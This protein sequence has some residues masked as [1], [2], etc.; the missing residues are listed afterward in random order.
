MCY[1]LSCRGARVHKTNLR[2]QEMNNRMGEQKSSFLT[3][4]T[5]TLELKQL[6]NKLIG[7][8]LISFYFDNGLIVNSW[9]F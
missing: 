5:A 3:L 8:K 7:R 6:I 1:L 2:G 9:V 4:G